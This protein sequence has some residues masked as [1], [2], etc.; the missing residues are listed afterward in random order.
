MAPETFEMTYLPKLIYLQ[1]YPHGQDFPIV[2]ETGLWRLTSGSGNNTEAIWSPD[3]SKIAYTSDRFGNWTLHVMDVDSQKEI[4][5]T[6]P[7]SIS[8][9][10]DWSPDGEKIAFWSYKNGESQIFTIKADG[11]DEQQLT[12]GSLLK[13]E[14][15]WRSDGTMLLFSQKD[16]Y[17]QI[18]IMALDSGKQWQISTT[19]EN[20]WAPRWMP[21][22]REIIYYSSDGFMLKAVDIE[23]LHYRDVLTAPYGEFVSDE[24][25]RI[26]PDGKK[27]LF[28]SL[29]SPNWGLWLMDIDGK[30]TKRL[31]HDGAGD[32]KASWSPDGKWIL[33]SSYRS[34]N[35]DIW[36][37]DSDGSHQTK[38]TEGGLNDLSPTWNPNREVIAFESDRLGKFDIWLLELESPFEA[39]ISFPKFSY[40]N[41]SSEAELEIVSKIEETIQIETVK[42]RFD[43]QPSESYN[44]FN[45]DPPLLL[46]SSSNKE[47]QTI[48]FD[49]P[50]DI[51][52]DYYLYD[53]IVEYRQITDN[54]HDRLQ[55]YQHTAKDLFVA[56]EE[57]KVYETLH[58]KVTSKINVENKKA[59]EEDYS[60][61][62]LE[63]NQELYTAETLALQHKLTEATEHLKLAYELLEQDQSEKKP[64]HFPIQT[65]AYAALIIFLISIPLIVLKRRRSFI[66]ENKSISTEE[67]L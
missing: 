2:A 9:W 1:P 15:L 57:R 61:S 46:T 47:N 30:N 33:Y 32:R 35:P 52:A 14:P 12:L 54:S 36:I 56:S 20:H 21:D 53:L 50:V 8:G 39:R 65:I 10:P 40:Q 26:S 38:L 41:T 67:V 44:I 58:E 63:A 7:D 66:H 62:L 6:S 16:E 19:D 60:E 45:F 25:P 18:W 13:S 42:L 4:Q 59:Q 43:W 23:G 64:L 31:T 34:A 3:G 55:I 48:T 27:I 49:I 51:V 5:L 22:G 37:M 11:T 29:R 17:W 24:R 28:N